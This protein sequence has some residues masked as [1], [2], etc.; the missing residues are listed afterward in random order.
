[1]EQIFHEPVTTSATG[2]PQ[3]ASDVPA[4]MVIVTQDDIRRSGALTIPDVLQFIPG[5]DVRRYGLVDSEVGIRGYNQP[6][7]SRLLV[8][9]DG[10]Q[11]YSDDYGH[12]NWASIPIQLE[13]IRQIEVIKGPASALYGFNAVSGVINIV[14]YDPL[15]DRVN[16]ATLRGGTQGYL[17]AA[18]VGTAGVGDR[19]GLRISAGGFRA[20]DF[21]PGAIR[22]VDAASRE[23]PTLGAFNFDGRIRV[24]PG[25]DADNDGSKRD[26]RSGEKS[27]Q[28]GFDT[29][30]LRTKSLRAGI[31]ADTA[32]GLLNLGAYHNG[33]QLSIGV[34]LP[35]G[36]AKWVT[37]DVIVAQASDLLKLG[38]DHTLRVGLEYRNNSLTAPGFIRGT[39]GY[40]VYAA[41]LM[42]NWQ[43]TPALAMTNAVRIDEMRLR[44]SGSLAPGTGFTMADYNGHLRWRCP[45]SIPVWC[46]I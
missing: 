14:T 1:M 3:R 28:G 30:V 7:N 19:A 35:D 36:F 13:E 29:A 44:Y 27:L 24:A 16:V 20:N 4:N 6:Y 10:R 9:V 34:P 23:N 41:N 46:T 40:E 33:Q 45:V 18:V 25:V 42:W 21:A 38:A 15:R 37:N 2:K 39:I 31:A 32:I 22:A 43:I 8:L 5:V 26:G 12:V 17:G 11:V